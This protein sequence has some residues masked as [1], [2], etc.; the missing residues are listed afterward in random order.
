MLAAPVA[1]HVSTSIWLFV[2]L[3]RIT[4]ERCTWYDSAWTHS[5][6]NTFAS[7]V[8][9]AAAVHDRHMAGNDAT[10]TLIVGG[11]AYTGHAAVTAWGSRQ[12]SSQCRRLKLQLQGDSRHVLHNSCKHCIHQ[13]NVH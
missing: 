6:I 5:L 12:S 8:K 4:Q 2:A 10:R 9:G 3:F 1:V 7:G 11:A 13:S